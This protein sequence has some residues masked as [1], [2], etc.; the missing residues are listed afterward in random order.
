MKRRFLGIPIPIVAIALVVL[1]TAGGVMAAF[2]MQRDIGSQVQIVGAGA[3]VY[4]DDACTEP[5]VE[6]DFG[7]IEA[8]AT[9]EPATFYVKNESDEGYDIYI[10]LSQDDLDP[11]LTLSED[12]N[13]TV[14]EDPDELPLATG[15]DYVEGYWQ[16]GSPATTILG[17][18]DLTAPII[19]VASIDGF[20]ASGDLY[21]EGEVIAYT[22]LRAYVAEG[23]GTPEVPGYWT[24]V[25]PEVSLGLKNDM[26]ETTTDD[27]YLGGTE[28]V[29]TPSGTVLIDDEAISYTSIRVSAP[30]GQYLEGITRGIDGTT[31][32]SH[33]ATTR[34]YQAEWVEPIPGIPGDA[35]ILAA[36]LSCTRGAHDTTAAAHANGVAISQADWV[37]E[38]GGDTYNL[39][40]NGVLPVVVYLDANSEIDR[41]DYPFTLF[42][43]AQDTQF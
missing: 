34:V 4:Q 1:L 27:I 17:G 23:E 42:V 9:S 16:A 29:F 32:A 25:Q 6:L 11:L 36:F 31:P 22:G 18:V 43:L 40:P 26:S 20:D 2:F 37:G 24:P 38:V 33:V 5:L 30:S 35:E 15:T 41:G 10:A 12:A 39:A 8:G 7:D 21:C 19:E 28:L 3:E 14:P 13:G